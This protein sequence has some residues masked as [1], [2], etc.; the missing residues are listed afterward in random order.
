M[1]FNPSPGVAEARD[2]AK[3]HGDDMVIVLRVSLSKNKLWSA[4]YGRTGKL[5]A[6][7]GKLSDGIH[8]H[9]QA[10]FEKVEQRLEQKG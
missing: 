3:K 6:V 2:I 7:A 1:S 10:V 4:S 9:M 5:C 8:E